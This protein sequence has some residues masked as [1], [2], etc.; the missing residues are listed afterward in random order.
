MFHVLAAK[1]MGA[2]QAG[3]VWPARTGGED[4]AARA[5]V[6]AVSLAV[7]AALLLLVALAAR[8]SHGPDEFPASVEVVLEAALRPVST[9]AAETA[10][11]PRPETLPE[12]ATLAPLEFSPP[13]REEVALPEQAALPPIAP[14]PEPQVPLAQP[15]LEPTPEAQSPPP[16]PA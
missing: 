9:L 7:H 8:P 13:P 15:A 4:G 2:H 16:R 1:A 14:A 5:V 10:T 11:V 6:V 12:V 3:P